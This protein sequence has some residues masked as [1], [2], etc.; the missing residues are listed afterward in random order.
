MLLSLPLDSLLFLRIQFQ[1]S[2]GGEGRSHP[3]I[4]AAALS[5]AHE[6]LVARPAERVHHLRALDVARG[7][8]G[9]HAAA[10]QVGEDRLHLKVIR[11]LVAA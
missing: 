1:L 6:V 3:F 5:S 4:R 2:H 11:R 9:G 10:A 7:A 8:R